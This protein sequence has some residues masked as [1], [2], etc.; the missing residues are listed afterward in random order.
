MTGR[1]HDLPLIFNLIIARQHNAFICA[2]LIVDFINYTSAKAI[3]CMSRISHRD[4]THLSSP[5]SNLSHHLI[6][7]HIIEINRISSMPQHA[8]LRTTRNRIFFGKKKSTH[9]HFLF[10]SPRGILSAQFSQVTIQAP[11]YKIDFWRSLLTRDRLRKLRSVVKEMVMRTPPPQFFLL[12]RK[13]TWEC[14]GR[15]CRGCAEIL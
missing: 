13:K 7:S 3:P 5:H 6:P 15:T 12:V 8:P 11:A 4:Q 1:N 10:F 9:P 14:R 2:F